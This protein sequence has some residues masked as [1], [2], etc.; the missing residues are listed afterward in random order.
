MALSTK[1]CKRDSTADLY[2]DEQGNI[3]TN[4]DVIFCKKQPFVVT[5]E[6]YIDYYSSGAIGNTFQAPYSEFVTL[7]EKVKSK[8]LEKS[9]SFIGRMQ[10]SLTDNSKPIKTGSNTKTFKENG[11]DKASCDNNSLEEL[12]INKNNISKVKGTAIKTNINDQN[13][14][15]SVIDDFNKNVMNILEKYSIM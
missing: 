9:R 10:P 7:Q 2:T 12:Y 8:K 11:K 14:K 15:Q 3:L 1:S 5:E 4:G 6:G 13:A